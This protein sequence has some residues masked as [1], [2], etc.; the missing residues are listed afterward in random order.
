MAQSAGLGEGHKII[1]IGNECQQA[2]KKAGIPVEQA[3]KPTPD[4]M[5]KTLFL[6]LDWGALKA[7]RFARLC[8]GDWRMLRTLA[9][10]L[11]HIDVENLSEKEFDAA[12][13]SMAKDRRPLDVVHPS[14]AAHQLFSGT[15][16]KRGETNQYADYS[17]MAWAERNLGTLCGDSIEEMSRM[18]E[19]ACHADALVAGGEPTIG[20]E[21]F[22]RAAALTPRAHLRYDFKAY[23]NPWQDVKE[24]PEAAAIRA[25]VDRLRP[26]AWHEKRRL[27]EARS[28]G[29][30]E[31]TPVARSRG[32]AAAT[33]APPKR[34]A[35]K[36]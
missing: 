24:R 17:V 32:G 28:D 7:R 13:E 9:Q 1:L 8:D 5:C 6:E 21:H 27:S 10:Q 20:L 26:W 11:A 29:T 14:L 15:A 33:K 34:K 4:E 18:Q 23:A 3:R 16:Q 35:A 19:A 36:T 30:C 31:P 25:N 2:A 22:A 12:L